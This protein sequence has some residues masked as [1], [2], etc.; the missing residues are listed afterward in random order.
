MG[1]LAGAVERL[2]GK[3]LIWGQLEAHGGDTVFQQ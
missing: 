2:E 3:G 1:F